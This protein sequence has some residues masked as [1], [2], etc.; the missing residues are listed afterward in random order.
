MGW[1][2]AKVKV[3]Q[4][5]E[6]SSGQ[7][8]CLPVFC[9]MMETEEARAVAI[10]INNDPKAAVRGRWSSVNLTALRNRL[11]RAVEEGEPGAREAVRECYAVVLGFEAPSEQW[12]YPHHVLRDDGTL[13]LHVEGVQAAI[14]RARQQGETRA[15]AHLR[16][17]AR[18]LVRAGIVESSV[19]VEED[20]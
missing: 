3:P 18:A 13:V 1:T 16:R 9:C 11:A 4:K 8:L 17:H 12:K 10:K 7:A 14:Q 6:R 19:L 2:Q 5:A 15:L 20:E